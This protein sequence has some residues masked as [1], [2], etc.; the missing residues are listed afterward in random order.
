MNSEVYGELYNRIRRGDV[1]FFI[2]FN[3]TP[4]RL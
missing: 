4:V 2:N 1:I 3:L